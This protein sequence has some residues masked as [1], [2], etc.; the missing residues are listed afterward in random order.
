MNF[1]I[2]NENYDDSAKMKCEMMKNVL[3]LHYSDNIS[4]NNSSAS[5][6]CL[7]LALGRLA[8]GQSKRALQ[9]HHIIIDINRYPNYELQ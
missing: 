4:C 9:L 8:L 3:C 2:M 5:Q 1:Q 7:R 6:H